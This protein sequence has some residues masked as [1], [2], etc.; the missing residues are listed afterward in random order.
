M[1][2]RRVLRLVTF[3][4]VIIASLLQAVCAQSVANGQGSTSTGKTDYSQEAAVI[5]DITTK[6]AFEN[7]GK[8]ARRQTTRVRVQTDAGIQAWGLLKFS[9]QSGTQSIEVA[10][11]R[12]RKPDGTVINTPED[13][14]QDLDAEITRSAPFYSDLREKHVA[15][16]GLGKGDILE[17]QV[18]WQQTKPLC[19]GQFWF[20]YNFNHSSVVLSE[21]LEMKV[22]A[23]R[24][25]KIKGP[26]A[27]K[28]VTSDAGWRT[29]AWTSS[30]LVST[31]EPGSEEKEKTDAAVGRTP[32]PEV[33]ISSFQ[34]WD[35]VGRWYWNLQQERIQPSPAIQAKTAEL[36]KGMT[37]DGAKLRALYQF[38]STQYRYIGIAFGI[39]RYQPHSADDVLTNNYG[40]CKDKHTLLASLLQAAGFTLY[41]ALINVGA[42]LDRDV[43]SPA[44]F[45]HVIGYL[46]AG[47]TGKSAVWLDTTAE[48]APFGYI[49]EQ[50]RN[51]QALVMEGGKASELIRTP[52]EP[53]SPNVETFKVEGKLSDDGTFQAKIEDSSRGDSEVV[54][55]IVFRRVPQPQWKDLV[56]QISYRLGF[57]GTVSDVTASTP[58][59]MGEPFRFAYSYNRKDYPD[60]SE[61]HFTVP[62]LLF[63]MPPVRDDAKESVVLGVPQEFVS[64]SKVEL[65]AG[66][67]AVMPANVDLKSDFA[68]YHASY[69]AEPNGI[70]VSRRLVTRMRE[71]PVA[72]FTEYRGFTKS[73]QNDVSQYVQTTSA[74]SPR[75][76]MDLNAATI[77]PPSGLRELPASELAEANGFETDARDAM[78][79][80]D[81]EG[82]ISSLSKAVGADPKFTRGW[83]LLGV[84][85]AEKRQYSDAASAL[86]SAV[87]IKVDSP[88][89]QATLGMMYMKAGEREKAGTAL[90]KLADMNPQSGVLND[91][92]YEMAKEDLKLPLA[93]DFAKK[94]VKA[95]EEESQKITLENLS[96]DDLK[97]V[98]KIAA[99][100]DTLGWVNERMTKLDDAERYLQASWK[101]TQDGVVAGHLC[102][103]YVREHKVEAAKRMCRAAVYRMSQSQ[104]I[105]IASYNTEL[106]AAQENLA[107]L[108]G[109]S[110]KATKF[111]DASND[112]IHEREFK[113]PKFLPGSESA[114][115]FVLFG[116]DGKSKNFRVEDVKY[117]SGSSRM[118]LEGKRLKLIDFK[119]PAPSEIPTRFVRRGILGC[120]QYTGCSFVL[121][122]PATVHSVD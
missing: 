87:K 86:E 70:K 100:W 22:P 79:K 76:V 107:R 84:L 85:L 88:E 42:T 121:L 57:A 25:V 40:D 60:W 77:R 118:K 38:V 44:Q 59:T 13:N 33:E 1:N 104:Q 34:S 31:K 74:R 10:Y 90:T 122:D 62:G 20:E 114:E 116:S 51:K 18:D 3:L 43:P 61:R 65:P 19:P 55:R 23:E 14:V 71:V 94:A 12:V 72:K 24:A 120:Y 63:Y 92:A 47:G 119:V 103:M 16:K 91:V 50:L 11:V 8:Y 48:V 99:Y 36:T 112:V 58:E 115:F 7:D 108:G 82:A 80:R 30:H 106:A 73:V 96:N 5:E 97:D 98:S 28:T 54:M 45:D 6:V 78:G 66:Y 9:Y 32:P 81:L 37:D 46:P 2:S 95:S 49:F 117:I 113:I 39:G 4:L 17:C 15:V 29:Y 69:S 93:L 89:L 35:E 109:G 26:S 102:H 75:V 56:Q 53:P 64:D 105:S 21:R 68:E 101:L 111:V 27:N 41:P 67:Q 83:V 52:A 110:T